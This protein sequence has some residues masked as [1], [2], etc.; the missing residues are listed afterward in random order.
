MYYALFRKT[1]KTSITS[2]FID[3]F[4]KVKTMK[5]RLSKTLSIKS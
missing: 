2:F 5:A 1:E 3:R 4:T